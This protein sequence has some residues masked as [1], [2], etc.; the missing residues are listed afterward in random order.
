M[1]TKARHKM[2]KFKVGQE[3][4]NLLTSRKEIIKA[5]DKNAIH[6][7]NG[8]IVLESDISFTSHT[9]L[10]ELGFEG[11]NGTYNKGNLVVNVYQIPKPHISLS[12]IFTGEMGEQGALI[13]FPIS[14][15]LL[16][17]LTQ[18]MREQGV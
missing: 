7:E 4:F 11:G 13:T 2:T 9:M 5:I 14:E 18:L 16:A 3:V 8:D 12:T 1:S 17:S 15:D 6:L 10:T